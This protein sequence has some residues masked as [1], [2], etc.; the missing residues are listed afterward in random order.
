M[1]VS[2]I[3]VT[4]NSADHI[5]ACLQSVRSQ[6]G[7]TF[8][9]IIVDNASKDNT[10]AQLVGHN[11]HLIPSAE[12]LGFGRGCNLGFNACSGRYIYLLNPDAQLESKNSLETLCR[13][14]DTH[15]KWGMAGTLVRSPA[16]NLE[17]FPATEYPGQRH[18]RRDFSKLPGRIA[19]VSATM[20][21]RRELYVKLGGFDPEIFLYSEETDFC[22]RMREIGFE[23]GH[24][25]EVTITHVGGASATP[26]D[27]YEISA[28]KL[29]GLLQ[30]RQKHYA[31]EDC[32]ALARRDLF[33]ARL[34]MA[35]YGILASVQ[36]SH[37]RAWQKN[38]RYRAIWEV[39]RDHLAGLG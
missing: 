15:P 2:I 14:M 6:S 29:K 13:M 23:I 38:R 22:L 31:P 8:E 16:G 24:I 19:W 17:S 30:F 18:V 3:I 5:A 7:V 37:S 35:W 20:I 32:V 10:Q 34:R 21:V 33:R 28:R 4:Y 39:S 25:P 9:T 11:V 1:D 12:N 36:P 27:P 26:N